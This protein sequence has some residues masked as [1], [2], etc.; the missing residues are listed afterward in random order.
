LGA[1]DWTSRNAFVPFFG[2]LVKFLASIT[3]VRESLELQPGDL[4]AFEPDVQIDP[5]SVELCNEKEEK[6]PTK[7]IARDGAAQ[8]ESAERIKPGLYRWM[9][10]GATLRQFSVNFPESESDLRRLDRVDLEGAGGAVLSAESAR[11][12]SRLREGIPIWAWCIAFAALCLLGEGALL[13]KMA[14]GKP[15]VAEASREKA[16]EMATV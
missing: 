11:A 9:A 3:G 2:E 8:M 4:P 12:I 1:T 15:A 7:G 16:K 14:R 10:E 6:V 5:R 13:R